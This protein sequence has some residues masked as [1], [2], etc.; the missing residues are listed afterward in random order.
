MSIIMQKYKV[1]INDKWIFFGE[2]IKSQYS[3][4]EEYEVLDASE[5]LIFNM[6]GMIKT[7]NFDR[8]IVLNQT[9]DAKKSFD[10]FLK[11]FFVLE[12]AGGIVR[13]SNNA[14]LMI[15]RFGFWDFPKGKIEKGESKK[16][17]ALREVQEETGIKNIKI[18]RKLP[19]KYH[20]YSYENKWTV[21]KTF[22]YLM[23]SDFNGKLKPQIEEDIREAVW[24]PEA[25]LANYLALTY[26]SLKELVKDSMLF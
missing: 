8:N 9:S 10:Y 3:E 19:T 2:F 17:A 26:N 21:K 5:H 20:I 23:S 25:E 16:E 13:H 7:G 11:Q 18:I 14:F 24:V 6:A 22:W 1:F 15:K 4:D 12:A